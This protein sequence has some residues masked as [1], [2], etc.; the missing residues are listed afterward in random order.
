MTES[1]NLPLSLAVTE[2][3][4]VVHG[5]PVEVTQYVERVRRHVATVE[6]AEVVHLA[7]SAA[8][9]TA[10]GAVLSAA[11]DYVQLSRRSLQLLAE[12]GAIPGQT[13]GYFYGFVRDSQHFAGNLEFQ[14]V[15]LAANQAAALQLAAACGAEG[16]HRQRREGR[17]AG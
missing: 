12:N 5:N 3:G 6:R 13:S 7:D 10:I 17:C 14:S 9:V 16:G 8:A 2:A 4:V 1:D 11:G 15:S